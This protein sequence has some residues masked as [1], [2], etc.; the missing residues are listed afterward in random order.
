MTCSLDF[1]DLNYLIGA[2]SPDFSL[3][4]KSYLTQILNLNKK[5]VFI[6]L[7]EEDPVKFFAGFL[8]AIATESHLFLLNPN[9][10]E[11]EINQVLNLAKPDLIFGNFQDKIRHKNKDNSQIWLENCQSEVRFKSPGLFPP[12]FPQARIMIPT[13]GTS[14]QVKFAIHTWETL[15]ASVQGF[16]QYFQLAKINSFCILP[17]YHVSGLMQFVRCFLTGG[18]LAIASY[19]KL[20]QNV[21]YYSIK[22]EDY[23]LSLVPT[24]LQYLLANNPEWLAKFKLVLVGGAATNNQLLEQARK[25]Q[26]KI[27]LTYGMTETASGITFLKPEDFL[28]GN[29]SNGKILPHAQIMINN[30]T[31]PEHKNRVQ[32]IIKVRSKSLFYGY[33]PHQF[34]EQRDFITDDIGYVDQNGYL[35]ILGRNSKKIITG[36]ENIFPQEIETVII[37]TGLVQ[38]VCVFGIPDLKWGEVAVAVYVPKFPHICED[39]IKQAIALK[40]TKYKIPKSWVRVKELPRNEQGKI[41]YNLLAEDFKLKY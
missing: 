18:K 24:Q 11:N 41:K 12:Q 31:K 10:Q 8:T 25:Y 7:A 4:A 32:G 29:N 28:R 26:I 14:G 38:D 21:N 20:K 22:P 39:T 35:Y 34:K 33:Y 1:N 23:L 3:L 13:G 17:L 19:K 27:A 30:P 5:S 37:A 16:S 2:N 6:F 36:G 9:W 15:S 40:L